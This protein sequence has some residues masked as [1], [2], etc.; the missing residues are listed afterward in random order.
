M[1]DTITSMLTAVLLALNVAIAGGFILGMVRCA[2][3]RAG[4]ARR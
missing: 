4:D 1:E 3:R 2:A